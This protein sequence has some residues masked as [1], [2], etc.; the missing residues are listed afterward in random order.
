MLRIALVHLAVLL[1]GVAALAPRRGL[2]RRIEQALETVGRHGG[3]ARA[4]GRAARRRGVLRRGRRGRGRLGHGLAERLVELADLGGRVGVAERPQRVEDLDRV[5]GL[6]GGFVAAREQPADFAGH[7]SDRVGFEVGEVAS[8]NVVLTLEGAGVVSIELQRPILTGLD[9]QRAGRIRKSVLAFIGLGEGDQ[10]ARACGS[11]GLRHVLARG[12]ALDDARRVLLLQSR[13]LRI[14][15]ARLADGAGDARQLSGGA[16]RRELLAKEAGLALGVALRADLGIVHLA[17]VVPLGEGLVDFASAVRGEGVGRIELDRATEVLEGLLRLLEALVPEAPE[18]LV[19]RREIGPDLGA[20]GVRCERLH[21]PLEQGDERLHVA[22]VAIKLRETIGRRP[23]RRVA[24][25]RLHEHARRPMG[26]AQG[27][28]P[29]VG[30]FAQPVRGIGRVPGLGAH[31]LEEQ[32]IRLRI[33]CTRLVRGGERIFIVGIY[34]EP[35][36]DRFDLARF[37]ARWN[38]YR[39]IFCGN[40]ATR[41][42]KRPIRGCEKILL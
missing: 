12:E 9:V 17:N 5:L 14:G 40:L 30:R 26:V 37:H 41:R 38:V 42:W 18:L 39:L 10:E 1:V 23:L 11:I 4:R 19:H 27:R 28:R 7:R 13:I 16:Q 29:D 36:D 25:D 20:L 21:A 31:A 33:R 6:V 8:R 32:R 2:L 15:L 22:L 35:L 3:T 34:D 24:L